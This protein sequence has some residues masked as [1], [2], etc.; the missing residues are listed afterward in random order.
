MCIRDSYDTT[1]TITGGTFFGTGASGMARSFSDSTQGILFVNVGDQ[2]AGTSVSISDA[3]GNVLISAA[4]ELS[5]SVVIFSS[6][7]VA[8]GEAYTVAVGSDSW[9]VQAA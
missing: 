6:P 1:A 2:A 8:S 5:F 7:D 9:E 3:S 4:P